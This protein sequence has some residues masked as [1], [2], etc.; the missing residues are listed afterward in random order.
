MG[1]DRRRVKRATAPVAFSAIGA[2]VATGAFLYPGFDTAD[3]DLHDA[4]I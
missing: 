1:I 3:L 4:G 2:V